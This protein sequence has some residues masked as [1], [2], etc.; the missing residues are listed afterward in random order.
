[1]AVGIA[2]PN[3]LHLAVVVVVKPALLCLARGVVGMIAIVGRNTLFS[4]AREH[5]QDRYGQS[6][7]VEL[8]TPPAES[9]LEKVRVSYTEW[10]HCCVRSVS[11]FSHQ[12]R[13]VIPLAEKVE[14]NVP[15]GVDVLVPRCW[16]EEVYRRRLRRVVLGKL[17]SELI[18][19][20][21]KESPFHL[22]HKKASTMKTIHHNENHSL[23]IFQ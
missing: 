16:F 1:M 22:E 21:R 12:D 3:W 11:G 6:P 7:G 15:I 19:F 13:Q 5:G 23:I 8:W 10:S 2:T 20:A 17:H 14:T 18:L 4:G 9:P